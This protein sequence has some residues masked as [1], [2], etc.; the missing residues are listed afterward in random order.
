MKSF[1]DTCVKHLQ[2][3]LLQECQHHV[4]TFEFHNKLKSRPDTKTWP[5]IP[6]T[7]KF[8]SIGNTKSGD[9]YLRTFMCCCNGCLHGTESCTNDVCPDKWIGYSLSQRKNCQVNRSWWCRGVDE[10]I[11]KI[12]ENTDLP[13]QVDWQNRIAALSAINTFE[14]LVAYVNNNP[15]PCFTDE[16]NDTI[17]QEIQNLDMV[18]LHHIPDD[19]PHRIAPISVQRDGNCFP[20]TISYLLCKSESRYMEIRVYI[21]YEAIQ[22]LDA[23]LDNIYVSVGAQNFYDC[24]TLPEQYAQYSGN[25]IHNAGNEL[26]VLDLYEKEVMDISKNSA[27]L[28]IWQIFQAANVL[29][30]PI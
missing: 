26:D 30:W 24:G 1:Y 18:A 2:K 22:N 15:L 8:H 4:P 21:V 17:T 7:R 23:Y 3:P 25:Y 27:F 11:R 10:Q 9:V 12:A 19:A 6:E 5:A 14:E 16:A 28:D 20:R 13:L 29:K